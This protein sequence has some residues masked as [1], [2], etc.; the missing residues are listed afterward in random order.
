MMGVVSTAHSIDVRN[1]AC[2]TLIQP[3]K[4]TI[5][6]HTHAGK[7]N[8]LCCS[9]LDRHQSC[10]MIPTKDALHQHRRCVIGMAAIQHAAAQQK[11]PSSAFHPTS[12]HPRDAVVTELVASYV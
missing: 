7:G 11:E 5:S 4:H 8:N 9:S 1:K 2:A 3:R 10:C 6:L 12:Y